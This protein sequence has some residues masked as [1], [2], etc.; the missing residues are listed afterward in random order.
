MQDFTAPVVAIAANGRTINLVTLEN[1]SKP[2]YYAYS[3]DGGLTWTKLANYTT[4]FTVPGP[5]MV[6]VKVSNTYELEGF[7]NVVAVN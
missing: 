6:M 3:M 5:G 7:S 2:L 4:S 1:E